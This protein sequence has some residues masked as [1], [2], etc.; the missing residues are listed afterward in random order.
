MHA[1]QAI[2]KSLDFIED[3]L[4]EDIT[5]DRLASTAALSPYYFQRLFSRLVKKPVNEYVKLRRLA[6]ASKALE[7]KAKRIIDVA[8]DCGFSNHANFTRA[9][10]DAYGITPDRKSVV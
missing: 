3:N 4:S 1:W 8:L 5:I 2:Q 9:F 7:N 6:K 10:I